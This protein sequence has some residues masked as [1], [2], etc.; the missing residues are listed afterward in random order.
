MQSPLAAV[1]VVEQMAVTAE[2]VVSYVSLPAKALLRG[3]L[4]QLL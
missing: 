4:S 3:T 1:V 2:V